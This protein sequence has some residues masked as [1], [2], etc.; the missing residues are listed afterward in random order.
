MQDN[1]DNSLISNKYDHCNCLLCG[2]GNPIGLG[3]KFVLLG[4][5]RVHTMLR[6][7]R[8]LQGYKGIIHGGVM[9]A[10]LDAAMVHCLFHHNV[11]SVTADMNIRF[12]KTIPINNMLDLY[13][14]LVSQKKN[15]YYMKSYIIC[16]DEIMVE[17][18]A[19]FMKIKV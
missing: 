6:G 16:N 19:R 5:G 9:C 12:K 8:L 11:K 3:L 4:D 14:E 7:S 2:E 13:G 1:K 18:S 10:L 15:L 17:G